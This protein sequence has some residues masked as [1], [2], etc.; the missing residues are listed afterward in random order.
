MDLNL[1]FASKPL[2]NKLHI[3]PSFFF[4]KLAHSI[5]FKDILLRSVSA[6]RGET[7]RTLRGKIMIKIWCC[8]MWSSY[9][10]EIWISALQLGDSISWFWFLVRYF[11]FYFVVIQNAL[12][13]A[14]I[15]SLCSWFVLRGFYGLSSSLI[16]SFPSFLLAAPFEPW[17]LDFGFGQISLLVPLLASLCLV[18]GSILV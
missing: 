4:F 7:T 17:I 14:H 16:F 9:K 15:C 3:R 5:T 13:P 12:L 2:I 11:R 10:L 8:N 6:Y 1:I 18:F